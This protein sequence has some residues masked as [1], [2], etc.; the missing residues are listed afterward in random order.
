MNIHLSV[1]SV[2][3][4]EDRCGVVVSFHKVKSTCIQRTVPARTGPRCCIS[5]T[6]C[7]A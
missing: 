7:L 2:G 3:M 5:Y 6:H 4:T 1:V